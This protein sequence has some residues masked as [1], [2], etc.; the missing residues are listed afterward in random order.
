MDYTTSP[1]FTVHPATGHRRHDDAQ[2]IPTVLTDDD[3]NQVTW[4]LMEVVKAA[5]LASIP[6]SVDVPASYT[7]LRDAILALM[8]AAS[9][10]PSLATVDAHIAAAIAAALANTIQTPAQFFINAGGAAWLAGNNIGSYMETNVFT[11]PNAL[12]YG[13]GWVN[14]SLS[15]RAGDSTILGW[16]RTS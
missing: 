11:S 2:A 3:I 15:Q 7:Q 8:P 6:F 10:A 1:D 14:T 13:G 12:G 9:T 16:V 5:Q 4:S